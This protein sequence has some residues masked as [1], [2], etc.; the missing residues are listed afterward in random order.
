MAFFVCQVLQNVHELVEVLRLTLS[1]QRLK[2]SPESNHFA[3][4]VLA[5]NHCLHQR[6]AL[7]HV[8]QDVLDTTPRGVR[9]ITELVTE[10]CQS[11]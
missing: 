4:G 2:S 3:E 10:L 1:P 5:A 9:A 6:F 11:A 7:G 8:A